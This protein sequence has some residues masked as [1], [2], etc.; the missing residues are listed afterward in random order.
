MKTMRSFLSAFTLIELLVVIAIIAIL[1]G[2]LLPALAAAREK[3]R[4]TACLNNLSQ[5]SRGLESY[6]SDYGGYFPSWQGAGNNFTWCQNAAGQAVWDNT[7]VGGA[8]MHQFGST[9]AGWYGLGITPQDLAPGPA[10]FSEA[11]YMP[12]EDNGVPTGAGATKRWIDATMAYT[13]AGMSSRSL[14]RGYICETPGGTTDWLPSHV[15]GGWNLPKGSL[16][17]APEQL[18]YLLTGGY[19]QD[20]GVFYCP[21]A[22]SMPADCSYT[23]Y[24]C[25]MPA[26]TLADWKTMGGRDGKTLLRGYYGVAFPYADTPG[27]RMFASLSDPW[28]GTETMVQSTYHYRN[29]PLGVRGP[30]HRYQDGNPSVYWLPGAKPHIGLRLGQ[31]LFPTQKILGSRSLVADTFSK[32]GKYD[33]AG[34]ATSYVLADNLATSRSYAGFGLLHHRDGYNVLYGDWSAKWYGDPQQQI[35][36]HTQGNVNGSTGGSWMYNLLANNWYLAPTLTDESATGGNFI[37]SQLAVWHDFDVSS[38]VDVNVN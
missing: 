1:A 31:P 9:K 6:C 13:Q 35:I 30:W 14:A 28:G 34:K 38:G 23:Y 18:G 12:A 25:Y 21:S 29:A 8:D 10:G 20:A 4:R 37:G 36:W 22:A 26:S 16:N 5:M 2:M 15:L 27:K 19:V 33:A 3:A 32:G 24:T 17:S 11:R 7:C